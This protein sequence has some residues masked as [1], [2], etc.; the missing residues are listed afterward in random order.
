MDFKP[1]N[2]YVQ[3]KPSNKTNSDKG[4]K[5]QGFIVPD[6]M[7]PKE[8]RAKFEIFTVVALPQKL[9]LFDTEE[10]QSSDEESVEIL[11]ETS[12]LEKAELQPGQFVYFI[13]ENYIVGIC[14]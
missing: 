6:E 8:K 13:R 3:V 1:A 14:E 12:M 10:L 7:I 2:R 5:S 9:D 4:G 11:I